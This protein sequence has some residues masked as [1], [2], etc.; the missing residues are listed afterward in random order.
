MDREF[1]S[2]EEEKE[3]FV[4]FLRLYERFCRVR[5]VAYCVMSNKF[6][7]LAEVPQCPKKVR[8]YRSCIENGIDS[9]LR[10]LLRCPTYV[11]PRFKARLEHSV[12][13]LTASSAW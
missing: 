12:P 3:Q 11:V 13:T 4:E 9:P 2:G 5:V 6:H 8:S 7:F 10:K 1:T